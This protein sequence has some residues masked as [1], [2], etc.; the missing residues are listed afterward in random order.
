MR[1]TVSDMLTMEQARNLLKKEKVSVDD[2]HRLMEEKPQLFCD[3]RSADLRLQNLMLYLWER[4]ILS[5]E[6]FSELENLYCEAYEEAKDEGRNEGHAQAEE[7]YS[8][9]ELKS[10]V[11]EMTAI[12]TSEK[13]TISKTDRL[14]LAEITFEIARCVDEP[15][16]Q[17]KLRAW[18][19]R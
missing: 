9:E 16:Q 14:N 2:L 1:S 10:L 12:L 13:K 11:K 17:T 5:E 7:N 6:N 8:I 15:D 18:W 19:S 4:K 3:K